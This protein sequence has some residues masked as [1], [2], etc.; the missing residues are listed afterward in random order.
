MKGAIDGEEDQ[1]HGRAGWPGSASSDCGK[2][3]ADGSGDHRQAGELDRPWVAGPPGAPGPIF[4]AHPTR[5]TPASFQGLGADAEGRAAPWPEQ[6]GS[7]VHWGHLLKVVGGQL[8]QGRA[9]AGPGQRSCRCRRGN[10]RA[11]GRADFGVFEVGSGLSSCI[12]AQNL[13]LEV[14]Y[15]AK[16]RGSVRSGARI[17]TFE[18]PETPVTSWTWFGSRLQG[19]P[20]RKRADTWRQCRSES[21]Q[22]TSGSAPGRGRRSAPG[23]VGVIMTRRGPG[24]G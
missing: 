2:I 18:L 13:V 19:G 17:L 10:L 3:I 8:G 15:P 14:G 24:G 23:G 6:P 1:G 11:P 12:G 22:P 7:R 16:R 4:L 20:G 9:D 5:S 21:R